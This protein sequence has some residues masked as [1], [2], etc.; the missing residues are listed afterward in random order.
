MSKPHKIQ[1]LLRD[2]IDI[3][4]RYEK[5]MIPENA[6]LRI[7]TTIAGQASHIK[8]TILEEARLQLRLFTLMWKEETLPSPLQRHKAMDKMLGNVVEFLQ[9]VK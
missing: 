3:S 1:D 5:G 6:F 4:Q 2:W 9:A 8:P 7:H